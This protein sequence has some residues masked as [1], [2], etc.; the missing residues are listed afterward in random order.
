LA[1]G[2]QQRA[3][4][5]QRRQYRRRSNSGPNKRRFPPRELTSLSSIN[6]IMRRRWT[7]GINGRVLAIR[8]LTGI[9]RRRAKS[10]KHFSVKTTNYF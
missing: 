2:A 10:R 3:D 1:W 7:H 4:G 6:R 8:L 5:D 9:K